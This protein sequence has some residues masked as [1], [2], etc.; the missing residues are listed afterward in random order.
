MTTKIHVACDSAGRARA[1]VVSGGDVSDW[2]RF[3]QVMNSIRVQPLGPGNHGPDPITSSPTRAR[4]PP[5]PAPLRHHPHHPGRLGPARQ[6]RNHGPRGCRPPTS[7]KLIHRHRNVVERCFNRLEQCRSVDTRHDRTCSTSFQATVTI[8]A[9][10]SCEADWGAL[11]HVS[12][13]I[14]GAAP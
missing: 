3:E 14:T 6:R 12:P 1:F 2:V 4:H 10:Q 5:I 8:A 7:N 13:D 9:P 11:S